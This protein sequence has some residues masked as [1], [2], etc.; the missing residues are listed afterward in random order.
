MDTFKDE[1]E[2]ILGIHISISNH[3]FLIISI[4]GPN[5]VDPVFFW[6]LRRCISINSAASIICGGIGT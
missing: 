6:D 2:N 3:Y 1:A 4:H 5:A